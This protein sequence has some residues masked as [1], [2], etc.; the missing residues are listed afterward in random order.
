VPSAFGSA[1][2]GAA[3]CARKDQSDRK[4]EVGDGPA[5]EGAFRVGEGQPR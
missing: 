1:V 5:R 2:N 3:V 4:L